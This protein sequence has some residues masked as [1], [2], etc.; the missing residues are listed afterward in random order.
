MARRIAVLLVGLS[1]TRP[2]GAE[3]PPESAEALFVRA[4]SLMKAGDCEQALP[5]LEQ[6]HAMEPRVGTSFNLAICEGRLGKLVEARDH[7][8]AV[9]EASGPGDERRAHAE[10]AMRELLPRIP[11]LVLE[12]DDTRRELERVR[13]DGAVLSELRVNEPYPINPGPHE[14]EVVLAEEA[15]QTRRFTIAERQVYTWSL[16]GTSPDPVAVAPATAGPS[17]SAATTSTDEPTQSMWTTKRKV[18]VV[19]AGT[20]LAAFGIGT[21]LA[22][23]ARSLYDTS[24]EDCP[25]GDFCN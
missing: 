17:S 2:A 18:A 7:L 23:S 22:L 3:P 25:A 6:S 1:M 15:P 24:E 8:R 21:G 14:L 5:L 11:S 4:R 20:S 12:L 13:L 10:R 16:G 9:I 19:A